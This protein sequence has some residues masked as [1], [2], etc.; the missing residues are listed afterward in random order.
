MGKLRREHFEEQAE[1]CTLP[2]THMAVDGALEPRLEGSAAAW[3]HDDEVVGQGK[4]A[5]SATARVIEAK[6]EAAATSLS[7][8]VA[9]VNAPL[10]D[11]SSSGEVGSVAISRG[12]AVS[13]SGATG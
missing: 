10:A 2:A 5:K 6:N 9:P 12:V 13:K 4:V 11:A 1:E 3:R 7:K 8:T